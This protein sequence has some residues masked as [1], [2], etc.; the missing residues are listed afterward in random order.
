MNDD[1]SN[2]ELD[3]DLCEEYDL[4]VLLRD[5]VEG[6]Y[7]GRFPV[8]GTLL[9]LDPD[10]ADAFPTAESVNSALR[11]LIEATRLARMAPEAAS[12]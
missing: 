1:V 9:V 11:L 7:A 5:S 2:P 12:V 6:R 4:D 3:D 10:I 8:D